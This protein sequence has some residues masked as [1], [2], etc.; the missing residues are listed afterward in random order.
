MAREGRR[1]LLWFWGE[2]ER[3]EGRIR[4]SLVQHT[5]Y[6]THPND[7]TYTAFGHESSRAASLGLRQTKKGIS[8]SMPMGLPL[9]AISSTMI[10]RIRR[11]SNKETMDNK[12]HQADPRKAGM[13]PVCPLTLVL[14]R[15]PNRLNTQLQAWLLPLRNPV[16]ASEAGR[17]RTTTVSILPPKL[18]DEKQS[19]EG[20]QEGQTQV[21]GRQIEAVSCNLLPNFLLQTRQSRKWICIPLKP[22]RRKRNTSRQLK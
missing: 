20:K 6:R 3:F 16:V 11:M 9:P 7:D 14:S 18:V 15:S 1:S 5:F 2:D 21:S 10:R 4:F 8:V 13:R 12:S 19:V 17:H 22:P